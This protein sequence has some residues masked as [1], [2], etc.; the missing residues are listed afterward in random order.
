MHYFD[1]PIQVPRNCRCFVGNF[2]DS[3]CFV[4]ICPRNWFR[5][6]VRILITICSCNY[7]CSCFLFSTISHWKLGYSQRQLAFFLVCLLAFEFGPLIS[8]IPVT[9]FDIERVGIIKTFIL[10]S[11]ASCVL[12]LLWI[13]FYRDT[14]QEHRLVYGLELDRIVTG[15]SKQN[16][17]LEEKSEKMSYLVGYSTAGATILI[18]LV[19]FVIVFAFFNTLDPKWWIYVFAGSL[20]FLLVSAF[21]FTIVV[22]L[23][24]CRSASYSD[25]FTLL[26]SPRPPHCGQ[27]PNVVLL[28]TRNLNHDSPWAMILKRKF[29]CRRDYFQTTQKTLPKKDLLCFYRFSSFKVFFSSCLSIT[30]GMFCTSQ[31]NCFAAWF[32]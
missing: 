3:D 32:Y 6:L 28:N 23:L 10:H 30:C 5:I 27:V 22:F 18:S 29:S 12:M 14:P 15:R 24:N 26:D 25:E 8:I 11:V 1:A 17:F 21:L 20:V 4:S 13:L 9:Y 19:H 16:R 2:C 7:Y 31:S